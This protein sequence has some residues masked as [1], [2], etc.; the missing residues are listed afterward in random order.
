MHWLYIVSVWLH[1][2]AA[3]TW[4]GGMVFLVLVLLPVT[5]MAEYRGAASGLMHWTGVRFRFVGWVCLGLLLASGIVNLLY[6]GVG[7]AELTSGEFWAGG[8]GRAFGLKM[9]LVAIIL[10]GSAIH[11]FYVGPRATAAWQ[12]DPASPRARSMRR[13]AT[14]FGRVNLLLALAVVILA[15]IMVRGWG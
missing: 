10:V 7:W 9:I 5:R 12:S 6:R 8:F 14:M 2:L 4:I 3:A 11:D 1:I 13:R 15:V